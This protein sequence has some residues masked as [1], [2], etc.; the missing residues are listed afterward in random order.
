MQAAKRHKTIILWGRG[1]EAPYA[2]AGGETL[3][4]DFL[5]FSERNKMTEVLLR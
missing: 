3:A 5:K 4:A 1:T 2:F